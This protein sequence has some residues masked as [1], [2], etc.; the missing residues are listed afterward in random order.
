MGGAA[1]IEMSEMTPEK[2]TEMVASLVAKATEI[3][4]ANRKYR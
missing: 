1:S 2:R 4:A 3:A